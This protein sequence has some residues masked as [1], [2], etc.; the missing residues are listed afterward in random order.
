[1]TINRMLYHLIRFEEYADSKWFIPEWVAYKAWQFRMWLL[2]C[3]E[4]E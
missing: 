1:M 2:E 4:E 3:R